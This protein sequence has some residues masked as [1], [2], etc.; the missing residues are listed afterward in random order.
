M[1][2]LKTK[3]EIRQEQIAQAALRLIAKHRYHQLSVASL[4]KEVGVVPSAIYRH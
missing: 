4:A 3:T 1:R 2:A